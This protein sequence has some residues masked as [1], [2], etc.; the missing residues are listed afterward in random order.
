MP[1]SKLPQNVCNQMY[2][3]NRR[4][5]WSGSESKR[6]FHLVNWETVCT[7]KGLVF[8]GLSRMELH[9]SVLL[10]KTAWRFLTEPDS[11]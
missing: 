3:L 6:A 8:I 7:P 5:L 4:F 11:L 10:L 2:M 1:T 9:N